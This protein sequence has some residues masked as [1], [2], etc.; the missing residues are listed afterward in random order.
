VFGAWLSAK[1]T[2]KANKQGKGLVYLKVPSNQAK[3]PSKG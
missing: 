1:Q 3:Q 2:D